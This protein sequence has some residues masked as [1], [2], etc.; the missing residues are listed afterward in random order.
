MQTFLLIFRIND[1]PHANPTPEQMQERM[2]WLAGIAAR[3]QLVDKGNRL[4]AGPAKTVKP[5]NI[6]TDGPYT[7]I[8][9]FI[10]GYMLVKAADIADAVTMA[11]ANP[12]L[13]MGGSVEVRTVLLPEERG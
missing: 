10:S 13:K 9:E 8:R 5:G 12:I 4:A 6:V 3:N 1:Q 2:N 11:Q 7:E